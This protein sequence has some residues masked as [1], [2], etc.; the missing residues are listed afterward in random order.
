LRD[1][2]NSGEAEERSAALLETELGA[3]PGVLVAQGW[4]AHI[5]HYRL[6]N[7]PLWSTTGLYAPVPYPPDHADFVGVAGRLHLNLPYGFYGEGQ[8]RIHS[9]DETEVP[10]Q[11][12]WTTEGAL[13]WRGWL[14][15]RSLD[16]DVAA[17]GLALGTRRTPLG[18]TYPTA[19]TGYLRLRGRVDNGVITAALENA[20]D[21]YME[22]DIRSGAPD[23]LTPFPVAG[24]TFYIGL[25]FYLTQ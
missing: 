3:H 7:N 2:E 16:L 4:V 13:H 25:S 18:V 14:F 6:D 8:G 22:S 23:F 9:R 24:R 10:Y 21:A 12:R 1:I 15:N 19:G 17:G 11:S 20:L 5:S